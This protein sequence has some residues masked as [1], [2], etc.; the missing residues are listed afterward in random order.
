[1]LKG[2]EIEDAEKSFESVENIYDL[3]KESNMQLIIINLPPANMELWNEKTQ[4]HLKELSYDLG[5]PFYNMADH[6]DDISEIASD[7]EH[8]FPYHYNAE[9]YS[10]AAEVLKDAVLKEISLN[11]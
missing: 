2:S 10:I 1:M 3:T 11:S 5:V 6:V 8:D 4:Q 9:G 7:I